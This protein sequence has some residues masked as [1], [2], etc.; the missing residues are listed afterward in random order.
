MGKM[1]NYINT[2]TVFSE[3]CKSIF[4]I[5]TIRLIIKDEKIR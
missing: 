3:T 1:I 5:N 2:Y 4:K